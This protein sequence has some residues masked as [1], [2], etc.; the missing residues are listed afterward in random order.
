MC[1]GVGRGEWVGGWDGEG[2]R[3]EGSGGA[4]VVTH[5]CLS[6]RTHNG[7]PITWTNASALVPS[8]G[9]TS[10]KKPYALSL[11]RQVP[12]VSRCKTSSNPKSRKKIPRLA[13]LAPLQRRKGGAQ[14]FPSS[15][16]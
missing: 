11:R 2:R 5:E 10:Q 1:G 6:M 14:P 7:I 15:R 4:D 3:R 9:L 16:R 13:H 8:A 12:G